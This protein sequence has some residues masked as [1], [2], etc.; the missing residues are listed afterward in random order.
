MYICMIDN[1]YI[2]IYYI[3]HI[4]SYYIILYHYICSP[5]YTKSSKQA[6]F[7]WPVK[8]LHGAG[9]EGNCFSTMH[10]MRKIVGRFMTLGFHNAYLDINIVLELACSKVFF[11]KTMTHEFRILIPN[12]WQIWKYCAYHETS[13]NNQLVRLYWLTRTKLDSPFI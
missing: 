12:D 2:Y 5:R 6:V 9:P 7:S 11:V 13:T 1:E 3:Y 10:V 4:I 8:Q